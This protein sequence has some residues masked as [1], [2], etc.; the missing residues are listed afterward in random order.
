MKNSMKRLF[1]LVLCLT[2]V[3]AFAAV[4]SYAAQ[5]LDEILNYQIVADLNEDGT[6]NLNIISTGRFLIQ[7]ATDP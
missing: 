3:F 1:A 5:P 4:T 6:V 7:T 2:V